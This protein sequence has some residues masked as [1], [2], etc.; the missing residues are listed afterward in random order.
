MKNY[1]EIDDFINRMDGV[2]R[3][4]SSTYRAKCPV[5][6]GNNRMAVQ[7]N[8]DTTGSVWAHC[9][10]CGANTFDIAESIGVKGE[11]E[12]RGGRPYYPKQ[13]YDSEKQQLNFDR[14][15][16]DMHERSLKKYEATGNKEDK[17]K[18]TDQQLYRQAKIRIE[19]YNEKMR[20]WMES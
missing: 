6:N 1:R 3:V 15:F 11:S 14:T 16:I 18:L 12:D 5:H 19:T 17:P 7:I 8:Y 10:S 4:S 9:Y 2:R 13:K 20:E